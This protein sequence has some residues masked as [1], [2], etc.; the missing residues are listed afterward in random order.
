MKWLNE[1]T[2]E[3]IDEETG[4]SITIEGNPNATEK[5]TEEINMELLKI[6]ARQDI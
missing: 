6:L 1:N 3:I 2:F 5:E 4:M